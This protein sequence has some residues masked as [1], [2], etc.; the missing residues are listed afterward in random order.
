MESKTIEA[1]F[2]GKT[3]KLELTKKEVESACS[4]C[5][6]TGLASVII[7]KKHN[8]GAM[9]FTDSNAAANTQQRHNF[10]YSFTVDYKDLARTDK[11]KTDTNV[12]NDLSVEEKLKIAKGIK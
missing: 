8:G 4:I 7:M 11:K 9:F 1:I 2:D 6:S 5:K 10:G 12:S 3:I